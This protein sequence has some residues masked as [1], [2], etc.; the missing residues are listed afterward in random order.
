VSGWALVCLA[1]MA[2]AL[3]TMAIAQM[4]LAW[5]IARLAKQTMETTQELRRDFRPIVDKLHRIAD[6]ATRATALGLTQLERIDQ[7]LGTAALRIDE[8]LTV[9]QDA[10]ITPVR[11]AAAVIAGLRAAYTAFRGSPGSHHVREDEDALFI[12]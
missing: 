2:V 3:V 11:H 12:G 6:D 4:A 10:I 7:M 8:T 5:Q 9:V 1:A